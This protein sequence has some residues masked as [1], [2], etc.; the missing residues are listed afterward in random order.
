MKLFTL[1]Y[2]VV[3]Y[4]V[5]HFPPTFNH[6]LSFTRL[7]NYRSY[8]VFLYELVTG[9]SVPY[10][11]FSNNDVSGNTSEHDFKQKGLKY[12]KTINCNHS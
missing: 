10:A 8:G 9:G 7:S 2:V 1:L 3:S 6:P 12:S 4:I 11:T 5:F